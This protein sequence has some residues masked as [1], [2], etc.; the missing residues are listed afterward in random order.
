MA[1]Q[2]FLPYGRQV[3]EDDDIA[4]VAEALRADYLTTGPRVEAFEAAFAETVGA[5]HAIACANGTAA[6]H[7]SMAALGLGPGES[8]IVPAITFV[9]TANAARFMGANVIFADVD[10]DTGLMTPQTLEAAYDHIGGRPL[11]AVLPVH[12]SGQAADLP[13]IR[14]FADAHGAAVVEDACHAVGTTTAGGA[15]RIGDGA[16]SAMACFSFHPVKT[17]TTGE[18]GMVTTNDAVLA[19]RLASLRSHGITRDAAVFTAPALSLAEDGRANPWAYEMQALGFNYRLPD[20]L[21][22]LGLSQLRKLPRFI[23]RRRGLAARYRERLAP[24]A[25]LVRF[26]QTP[27]GC[28]PALHLFVALIDFEAAGVSRKAVV[29]ALA[30]RGI[31]TQV[32]Y[33]PVHRQPYYQGLGGDKYSLPGADAW[34][35]RALSLPLFPAMADDDPDRVVEALKA[36]LGLT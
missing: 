17:L 21:C 24:L 22:A 29:E 8:V 1:D 36:L 28:D 13:A 31:G 15:E 18:G 12:L 9:A 25:P 4:A 3:I 34:Y 23:A 10:P 32:H 33:I 26:Q 14:A 2:P 27:A 19:A 6:L 7:L 35:A 16:H 30:A 20:I 5:R 11:K